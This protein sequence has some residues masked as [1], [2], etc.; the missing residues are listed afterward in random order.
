MNH[1]IN[2]SGFI[3]LAIEANAIASS[4]AGNHNT[5]NCKPALAM[6]LYEDIELEQLKHGAASATPSSLD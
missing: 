6:Y 3:D 4:T 2:Y 5:E 1:S